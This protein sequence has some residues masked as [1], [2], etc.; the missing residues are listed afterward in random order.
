MSAGTITVTNGSTN[1]NGDGTTFTQDVNPS[2][3]IQTQ[4]S[5]IA[6]LLAVESIESDTS[7]TLAVNFDGPTTS[8]VTYSISLQSQLI[9][10]PVTLIT[11]TSQALREMQQNENNWNQLLTVDGDVTI[12]NP[13]GTTTTGP[14]WPSVSKG[15]DATNLEKAQAIADQSSASATAA[16]QSETNAKASEDAAAQSA[17]DSASSAS[18]SATSAQQSAD[19]ASS[20]GDA[21]TQSAQNASDA[22]ASADRAEAAASVLEDNNDL[23]N[24]IDHVDSDTNDI[25]FK[26]NISIG[27][28]SNDQ[29]NG[30]AP[31]NFNAIYSD[32]AGLA[33]GSEVEGGGFKSTY[34]VNETDQVNAIFQASLVVGQS[35]T[36]EITVNDFS[37]T[38][39]V[40][41]SWTM[42]DDS[43]Q[44]IRLT[45]AGITSVSGGTPT[46]QGGVVLGREA[47]ADNEAVSLRQLNSATAGGGSGGA[48]LT[49]VMN[50]F[51]GAVEWFNGT[52]AAVPAGYLPANGQVL[53]RADYPDLWAAVEAGLFI[54][55]DEDTWVNNDF[56]QRAKYSTGPTDTQFRLPDLN[57]AQ[58]NSRQGLFLSGSDDG[59]TGKPAR[60]VGIIYE[61]SAPDITGSFWNTN[62]GN[63]V[64]EATGAFYSGTLDEGQDLGTTPSGGDKADRQYFAA[65]R[66]DATYGRQSGWLIPHSATGIWLIRVSGAFES[67]TT[68]FNVIVS[69]DTLPDT[70]SI[71]F[72]G[73]I[74]SVYNVGG[75][76]LLT[77]RMES[78]YNIGSDKV[79]DIGLIDNSTGTPDVRPSFKVHYDGHIIISDG[80]YLSYASTGNP[81]TP[82]GMVGRDES[83]NQ[84][85]LGN[86]LAQTK[87]FSSQTVLFSGQTVAVIDKANGNP[88]Y[89]S[90]VTNE[91]VEGGTNPRNVFSTC[92]LN[93]TQYVTQDTYNTTQDIQHRIIVVNG[94][95]VAFTFGANG[96]GNAPGTWVNGS[97]ERIKEN[98]Q[99]ISDVLQHIKKLKA[100]TYTKIT[101]G[102]KEIGLIANEVETVCPEAVVNIGKVT[103][104]DESE[105]DDV[106]GMAYGNFAAAF[107]VEGFKEIIE[108][109]GF[110]A[111]DDIDGFKEK[112]N[113]IRGVHT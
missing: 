68:N 50:D 90:D 25:Y 56:V 21:V 85:I 79:V 58:L 88:S 81:D 92:Y 72:G 99:P 60:S 109:F 111:D 78:R 83:N 67:A 53:N 80:S 11:Q 49:G 101:T 48:T 45:D 75:S 65:S 94:S 71:V 42:P 66:I 51:V 23:F 54:S 46:F 108:L 12:T 103:L 104:P 61:Q 86:G 95:A 110:L 69:D 57:G 34:Q 32:P 4:I 19:S 100:Y 105:L 82:V 30:E 10:V 102:Q 9:Q 38:D 14:S 44:L 6:Y 107:M 37:S 84:V 43:G 76:P 63:T 106:L 1:V 96:N 52:P 112:F 55:T 89:I 91:F 40:S 5:G 98:V 97:D 113:E 28:E 7:L 64:S 35:P 16:A 18:D 17:T 31:T 26:G 3:Y 36:A 59:G 47:S 13:D 39:T 22:S 77:A 73:E 24:A 20:I 29:L 93:S 15:I 70:G 74:N 87:V 2:D 62:W 8:G 33:P 27:L 41:K